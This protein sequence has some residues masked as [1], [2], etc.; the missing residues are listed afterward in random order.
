MSFAKITALII[1]CLASQAAHAHTQCGLNLPDSAK[2]FLGISENCEISFVHDVDYANLNYFT[3][4]NKSGVNEIL[5]DSTFFANFDGKNY[6]V[7]EEVDDPKVTIKVLGQEEAQPIKAS[8]IQG[9]QGKSTL[10]VQILPP[11]DQKKSRLFS[12]RLSCL[13]VVEG[14]D[15]RSFKGRFCA[16]DNSAGRERLKRFKSFVDGIEFD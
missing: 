14:N 4:Y 5:N 15:L 12:G 13:M 2:E 8:G 7:S 3:I 6:F 16:P 1:V 10:S 9:Y 11:A